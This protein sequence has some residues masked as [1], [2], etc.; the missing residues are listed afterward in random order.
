MHLKFSTAG[1]DWCL[2]RDHAY[3]GTKGSCIINPV[4]P[5]R[6][7]SIPPWT[8]QTHL[9]SGVRPCVRPSPAWAIPVGDL[10]SRFLPS[11]NLGVEEGVVS[12]KHATLDLCCFNAGSAS[13][14]VDQQQN[15]IGSKFPACLG[16]VTRCL[17]AG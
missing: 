7:C 17:P 16:V 13:Q 10:Q 5:R 1:S 8:L 9:S 12:R 2:V 6:L 3:I 4:I 11:L 14:T 15:S